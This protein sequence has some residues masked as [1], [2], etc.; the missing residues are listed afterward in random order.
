MF[1][2]PRPLGAST[3][4]IHLVGSGSSPG[5]QFPVGLEDAGAGRGEGTR[6]GDDMSQGDMSSGTYF[7]NLLGT[8]V[9]ESQDLSAS[10]QTPIVQGRP[11]SKGSQGKTK[12]FTD[13]ED[14]LLVSA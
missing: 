13:E 4:G 9:E 2:P 7:T 10:A 8:D 1:Q 6:V 11:A 5:R 14:R 3:A 12:N